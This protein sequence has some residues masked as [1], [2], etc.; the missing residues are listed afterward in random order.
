MEKQVKVIHNRIV[1]NY[2]LFFLE[3]YTIKLIFVAMKTK[4]LITVANYAS[5]EGITTAGAYKRIAQGKVKKEVI[6]GVIFVV[7]RK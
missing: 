7:V 1:Y 6:D 5:K 3:V 2:N 4:N